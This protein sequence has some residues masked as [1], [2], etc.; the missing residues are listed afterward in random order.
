MIVSAECSYQTLRLDKSFH[1]G[2]IL[3]CIIERAIGWTLLRKRDII[4]DTWLSMR[5]GTGT[6]LKCKHGCDGD[7]KECQR[8]NSRVINFIE[9]VASLGEP[10]HNL[11]KNQPSPSFESRRIITYRLIDKIINGNDIAIL[12]N[13]LKLITSST[14]KKPQ[15]HLRRIVSLIS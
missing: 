8:W 4:V 14:V 6:V 3:A 13:L 12:I 1:K 11:P 7:V 5:I 9:L 10:V 15:N 2:L